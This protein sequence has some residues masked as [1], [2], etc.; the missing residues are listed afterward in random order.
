M[1]QN[2]K[3]PTGLHEALAR[4]HEL[5]NR[6]RTE[7]P[8]E[9]DAMTLATIS[10]EGRSRARTVLLKHADESGFVFYTNYESR[11][12]DD[13]AANPQAALCFFW[14]TLRRQI[15]VEGQV[16]RLNADASDVYFATRNRRAQLGAWAS[17]QSRSL[18][19]RAELEARL[20][21]LESKYAGHNVPRPPH[22]GGYC[23]MPDLIE[24]WAPGEGRLNERER[25]FFDPASEN[26][27]HELL[28]P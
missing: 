3:D 9:A 1:N 24:F 23:L 2:A 25:Y 20:S 28:N 17:A 13:L 5:W 18:A 14:R 11:K 27:R 15:M 7:E 12:G 16:Q 22:W 19:S 10:V 21:E 6:A 8:W 26:W 4:F